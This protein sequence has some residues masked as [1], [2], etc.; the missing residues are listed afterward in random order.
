MTLSITTWNVN[1]VRAH[2]DQVV[3]WTERNRPDVLCLQET[4]VSAAAFPAARFEALGYLCAAVGTGGRNG[5]AVCSRVGLAQI[6]SGIAGAVGPFAE[7]RL[8]AAVCGGIRVRCVYVPNGSSIGT[9]A[10]ATKLAYF[11]FLREVVAADLRQPEPLVLA[12]DL[13][14]APTDLDVWDAHRYRRRN[15]TSPPERRSF[16][17]LLSVGLVDSVR[18]A[19]PEESLFTWWNR[20]GDFYATDRGWRL[21]HLLVSACLA[22]TVGEVA[23][24]RGER[25]TPGGSDHA[26]LTVWLDWPTGTS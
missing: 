24:D 13:N 8:V 4:M 17:D 1:S 16:E 2:L 26:P 11:T 20:R 21:D 7:P 19:H 15:L 5:V 14:V 22:P 3:D 6:E 10:H 18:A 9:A 12:G 23:V 25:S